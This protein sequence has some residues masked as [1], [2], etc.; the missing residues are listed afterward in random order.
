MD[1][2][3]KHYFDL[4]YRFLTIRNRSE[5]EVRD[6]LQKKNIAEVLI[7]QIIAKLYDQKFLDDEQFA[8]SFIASR[9]RLKP[10]GKYALEMELRQKG[11]AEEI[12]QKV[13]FDMENELPS[14]QEQAQKLI[15]NKIERVRGQSRQVIYQKIGAFLMRRGYSWDVAKKA[16]DNALVD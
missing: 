4:V 10:K 6:Y 2:S 9:A 11:I 15:S 8:T 3:L 13:F 7:E 5:K 12:I 14:E 1:D 16:I